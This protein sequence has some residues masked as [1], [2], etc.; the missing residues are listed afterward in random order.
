MGS[1]ISEFETSQHD[2]G[3]LQFLFHLPPPHLRTLNHFRWWNAR[4][5]DTNSD[6]YEFILVSSCYQL[7]TFRRKI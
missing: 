6:A 3:A 4:H 5:S 1:F 2:A 7:L